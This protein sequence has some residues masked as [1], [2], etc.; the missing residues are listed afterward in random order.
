MDEEDLRCTDLQMYIEKRDGL[1][2][3]QRKV[4]SKEIWL[5]DILKY[6]N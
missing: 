6:Y 3:S 2:P 1:K 4:L 5:K